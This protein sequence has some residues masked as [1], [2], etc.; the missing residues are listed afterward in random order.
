ML[1]QPHPR[2]PRLPRQRWRPTRG[3]VPCC[4]TRRARRRCSTSADA[5]GVRLARRLAAR[6]VRTIG[7]ALPPAAVGRAAPASSQQRGRCA[8][9]RGAH[10]HRDRIELG[11]IQVR[12][13]HRRPL[14]CGNALAVFGALIA[15]GVDAKS[16]RATA[17]I[18]AAG[19]GP[20]AARGRRKRLPAG[21]DRLRAY[22]GRAGEG[23]AAAAS[24]GATRRAGGWWC[25]FGCGGDRDAT[26]RPLMGAAAARLPIALIITSDNPRTEDPLAIIAGDPPRHSARGARPRCRSNP[27]A[28]RRSRA[29]SA[30]AGAGDVVLIAGKGHE[31]YQDIAGRRTA[32]ST[33]ARRL[34][35]RAGAC[36]AGAPRMMRGE[37]ARMTGGAGARRAA[38]HRPGVST[39]SRSIARGEPLRRA[40]R[41]ALRRPR[42]PARAAARGGAPRGAGRAAASPPARPALPVLIGRRHAAA[43]SAT[44]RASTARR[45]PP[46]LIAITG[47]TARPPPR[48]CSRAALVRRR[49]RGRLKTR[50]TSTTTIGLPLTL[51]RM[52]GT[53]RLCALELGTNHPGEIA[54]LARHRRGRTS[55]WSPTCAP[56]HLEFLHLG[57]GR[58]A[59]RGRLSRRCRPTA[60]RC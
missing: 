13:P 8:R 7:Y 32:S 49:A 40:A 38:G 15:Y 27:T 6:G 34:A 56:A 4:S 33:T 18:A 59:R 30:R 10:A 45:F 11:R 16:A 12:L 36:S 55:A 47:S 54:H 43:R 9:K 35:R 53:H 31:D 5:F 14:Q 41:R 2:P 48:R 28:R 52:R 24:A 60:S 57:R 21:R 23:A 42:L 37:A 20:H 1:H 44:S 25:V 58:E 3:Q 50:A 51:L 17:R 39:D 22:A 19:R 46:P 29:R 26:K